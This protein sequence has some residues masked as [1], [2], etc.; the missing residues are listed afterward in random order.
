MAKPIEPYQTRPI[1]FLELYEAEG[2]RLKL[3]G[4]CSDAPLPRP[5]LIATM[6]RLALNR[7]PYP[8]D[9]GDRYGVGFAGVHQG[10]GATYVFADW[11]AEENEIRHFNFHAP[12]GEDHE[13]ELC[14]C[15]HESTRACH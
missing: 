13:F 7:L 10:R 6:K 2:W 5:G 9:G 15:A 4:I 8:A 12:P 14:Q 11:W 1:R 3:Y